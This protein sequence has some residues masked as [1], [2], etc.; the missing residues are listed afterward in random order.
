MVVNNTQ[1]GCLS[2]L[3]VCQFAENLEVGKLRLSEGIE[4]YCREVG[5]GKKVLEC[6]ER[7]GLGHLS[8][9]SPVW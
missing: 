1:L 3:F 6:E 2:Y 4:D 8:A 7:R 9:C 5:D